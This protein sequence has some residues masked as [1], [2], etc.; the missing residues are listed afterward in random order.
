MVKQKKIT[1]EM[2]DQF[3][4]DAEAAL[5]APRSAHKIRI[6]TM[7]DGDVLDA[8]KK[9]AKKQKVPYQTLLNMALREMFIE[10]KIKK[11]NAQAQLLIHKISDVILHDFEVKKA[12]A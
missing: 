7:V 5:N 10:G 4:R 1:K 12:K 3:L 11:P 6:T 2:E 8:L 9:E